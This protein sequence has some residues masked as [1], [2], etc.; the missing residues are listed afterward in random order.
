VDRRGVYDPAAPDAQD[1]LELLQFFK[2][3]Q[4]PLEEIQRQHERGYIDRAAADHFLRVDR[5]LTA[6]QVCALCALDVDHL[7]RAWLALGY[8]AVPTN[9][10]GYSEADV[11][12][13]VAFSFAK[14]LFGVDAALQF[15]RVMGTSLA[16]IADAAV[17]TF[18]VNVEDP[19]RSGTGRDVEIARAG[20]EG[21]EG[22]VLLPQLF[23]QMFHRHIEAALFQSRTREPGSADVFR[24]AVGFVDLVGYTAW[25]ESL[26]FADLA[27]AMS[28][29]E[30]AASDRA[31]ARGARVVKLIGDAVMFVSSDPSAACHTALDI[32]DDVEQHPVLTSARG[33]IAFGDLLSRDG[34]Y[35][36][37]I[38][39][40]AARALKVPE[41]GQVVATQ[42]V[43][44]PLHLSSIGVHPLRGVAAPTELFVV[45]R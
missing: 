22:L 6:E 24:L 20:V 21:L 23:E 26:T 3:K 44:T 7:E 41:P 29:F 36:G 1:R 42:D 9:E 33:A 14:N 40:Q 39:N 13:L 43:T 8:P 35:F 28:Y 12:M 11:P 27:A 34:D 25:S 45:S 37:P 17:S 15:T 30:G 18:M 38:V 4:V 32:I 2:E 31:A 5:S 10:P 16:R 19:L